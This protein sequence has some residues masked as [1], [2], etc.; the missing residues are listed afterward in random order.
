MAPRLLVFG[1]ALTAILAILLPSSGSH[2]QSVVILAPWAST[3]SL[4]AGNAACI[5]GLLLTLRLASAPEVSASGTNLAL[6]IALLALSFG[7]ITADSRNQLSN[8]VAHWAVLIPLL[9]SGAFFGAFL[10]GF[11]RKLQPYEW[12]IF[13]KRII[14]NPPKAWSLLDDTRRRKSIQR[15]LRGQALFIGLAAW[16]ERRYSKV[17]L[18]FL[19]LGVIPS[20]VA[21]THWSM[22]SFFVFYIAVLFPWIMKGDVLRGDD[23][24]K[25]IWVLI[26]MY[27]AFGVFFTIFLSG[28][29]TAL[30]RDDMSLFFGLAPIGL[31]L[32]LAFLVVCLSV[33]VLWSGAVDPKLA[34]RRT[35]VYGTL[36]VLFI[37]L[38]AVVESLVSEVVEARLGLPDMVGAAASGGLVAAIILPLRRRLSEFVNG[39][40]PLIGDR[41]DDHHGHE[42]G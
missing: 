19:V 39:L 5:V 32:A 12:R 8:S 41:T 9:G 24:V 36:G 2:W 31:S 34:I 17:L 33:A 16:F 18:V 11:P 15:S 4:L 22:L 28:L 27:G 10:T 42:V 37:I 23:R 26:G 7:A 21:A 40:I 20:R 1:T 13:V 29:I 35:T 30:F 6:G 3:P 38:F 14:R 25:A